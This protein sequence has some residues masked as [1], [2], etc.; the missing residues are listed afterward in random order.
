MCSFMTPHH[1]AH[2]FFKDL[3]DDEVVNKLTDLLTLKLPGLTDP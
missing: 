2:S 3:Q 1:A